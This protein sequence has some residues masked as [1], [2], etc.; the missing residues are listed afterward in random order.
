VIVNTARI[1][2]KP[3]KQREFLQTIKQLL[4]PIKSAKGCVAFNIYIDAVDENSSLLVS[5]WDTEADLNRHLGSD[6]FAVLRGAVAALS[7]KAHEFTALVYAGGRQ[8]SP[9]T[10]TGRDFVELRPVTR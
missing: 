2:V 5:E 1:T 8:S 9:S 10:A 3:E 7:I 6:D 4:E